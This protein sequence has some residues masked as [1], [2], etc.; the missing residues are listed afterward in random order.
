[1]NDMVVNPFGAPAPATTE[2]AGAAALANRE[3][4]EVQTAMI[5]ARNFPRDPR[6]SM[7]KILTSCTRKS[8]AEKAQYQYARGGTDISG[9][10]IKLA[11]EI[12]RGWGN[13]RS[14]IIEVF[15][16]EG[17]SEVCAYAWDLESGYFDEKRW[18]VKHWRD[19]RSGGYALKDERDIYELIANQGQRRKRACILAVVP[20]DVVE[21][22]QQQC[23]KTLLQDFEVTPARIEEMLSMFAKFG[24]TKEHIETHVQRRV[25]AKTL[26]PAL[27]ARLGRIYNSLKDGMSEA[28]DWFDIE[29][30]KKENGN[31][32]SLADITGN[33]ADAAPEK[34]VETAK[35]E[36]S[37]EPESN[38]PV[39]HDEVKTM[40]DKAKTRDQ[41]DE[42][43]D[44]IGALPAGPARDEL[45][46]RVVKRYKELDE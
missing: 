10:S 3:A 39:T 8:L 31:S 45:K 35:P 5:I 18:T 1:M 42:A 44:L 25:D 40:L 14:G 28:S 41:L 26:T 24:V 9:P 4:A 46:K 37:A 32:K 30:A 29:T 33:Q 23:Q 7:D 22:A 27:L 19:T 21:I 12:A 13:I 11:E 15:R 38:A 6:K 17:F 16:G 43:A 2:S 34:P 20:G 36:T